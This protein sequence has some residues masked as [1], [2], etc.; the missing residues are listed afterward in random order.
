[1]KVR[2]STEIELSGMI[3]PEFI[4][5]AIQ[6]V[7]EGWFATNRWIRK[8]SYKDILQ[9]FADAKFKCEAF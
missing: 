4:T 2:I 9:A 1:M 5:A 6:S 7:F 3:H 8:G